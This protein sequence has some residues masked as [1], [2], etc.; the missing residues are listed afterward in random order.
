MTVN[1]D[2]KENNWMNHARSF[3][4]YSTRRNSSRFA[5]R[6]VTVGKRKGSDPSNQDEA[7]QVDFGT[8]TITSSKYTWYNFFCKNLFEQFRR[9]ANFYFLLMAIVQLSIDSPVNPITSISPLIF[10]VFVTMCKQGYEDYCRHRND[11]QLNSKLVTIIKDWREEEQIHSEDIEVGDIV[12]VN[13]GESFPCDLV[14]LSSSHKAGKCSVKTA[15]IDG[16]TNLK[17]RSSLKQTR[18]LQQ[19][20]KEPD[21]TD[22]NSWPE[23]ESLKNLQ[24]QLRCKKPSA[25]LNEF[26][27]RMMFPTSNPKSCALGLDNLLMRGTQ[28]KNTEWTYGCA[29]Y[30][31]K[32]TKMSMNSKKTTNKFSKVESTLNKFLIIYML[33]LAA[34][35]IISASLKYAFGMDTPGNDLPWYLG[36]PVRIS[37]GQLAQDVLSFLVLYN[38]IIPI[39]LYVTLEVQKFV[40]AQ[41]FTWDKHLRDNETG[42]PAICNSSDLNEELGQVQ[43][44]FSDKTGTLTQNIMLFKEASIGGIKYIKMDNDDTSRHPCELVRKDESEIEDDNEEKIQHFLEVLSLCH[45]V[46]ISDRAD[47][48]AQSIEK[49]QSYGHIKLLKNIKNKI[50]TAKA[51]KVRE[52]EVDGGSG[53][54]YTASSPD[55]KAL[56]EACDHLGLSFIKEEEANHEDENESYDITV[57]DMRGD[58]IVERVFTRLNVLEFDSTRKR[59]SVIVRDSENRLWLLAKGAETSIIDFCKEGPKN[60]TLNHIN[61]YAEKGLRTLAVAAKRLDETE[62]QTFV[63]NLKHAKESMVE[64]EKKV[65]KVYKSMEKDLILLGATAVEDKLQDEVKETLVKLR[66]AGIAVW[67]LTGDKKETAKNIS[68]SCNHLVEPDM[69]LLDI[70]KETAGETLREIGDKLEAEAGRMVADKRY[71]LLVDGQT[72]VHIL[73]NKERKTDVEKDKNKQLLYQIGSKCDAVICC[74][75][76]PLQ[77]SEIVKMMKESPAK[78]T[79]AAVGDGGNDVAMIQEAHVG[80]GIAGKEGKAATRAADFAFSQ[81][82]HLQRILLVH[83]HWYYYRV[84]ILVQYFF[85]KNVAC[86]TGQ[87]FYTMFNNFSTQSLYG[88]LN[89]TLYNIVFTSLP[90]FVFGLVEQNISEETL[91]KRPQMYKTIANNKKLSWTELLLWFLQGLWH[92]VVTFFGWWYFWS[93]QDS[94][95]LT[96]NITN[97]EVLDRC[98]F[99]FIIYTSVVIVVNIK[100]LIV[101]NSWNWPLVGSILLSMA[102]QPLTGLVGQ[103]IFNE[104]DYK[105]IYHIVCSLPIW[106]FLFSIVVVCLLPDLA[107]AALR[108]HWKDKLTKQ[109][110]QEHPTPNIQ[111]YKMKTLSGFDNLTYNGSSTSI[112][113]N[114]THKT[115]HN[116]NQNYVTIV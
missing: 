46:Q 77:K 65:T 107:F 30:T 75:M 19:K 27:G 43:I 6:V 106:L 58:E 5:H 113:G 34:E 103:T 70:T 110:S 91:L 7:A 48:A 26:E 57:K 114:G 68:I 102:I 11:N 81:F 53:M 115:D 1:G 51:K 66:E 116:E 87:V 14:L 28:L 72:L 83:G 101:A 74:R 82:M 99:G 18:V 71:A 42:K 32:D 31:G 67:V 108:Q 63:K 4:R 69:A 3:A 38:Y 97:G 100:L 80:L 39:S 25:N 15:N 13:D 12:K 49:S 109:Q 59:M 55:E 16:E 111:T 73:P 84:A 2:A 90:I 78:P 9:V 45:T 85:Y 96:A 40:G 8:N 41:F 37:A 10:V 21:G 33:L 50:S 29:V 92:S 61:D 105:V 17:E 24:M 104:D 44:L 60:A 56:V 76:S 98:S 62:Y 52:E 86:F 47:C 79:T 94:G 23:L 64:R 36:T 35:V 89:L 93:Y 54:F 88:S 95:S 20:E 22:H 112:R